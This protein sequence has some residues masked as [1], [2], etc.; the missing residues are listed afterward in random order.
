MKYLHTLDSRSAST[1]CRVVASDSEGE[2][3][4]KTDREHP[5]L[6]YMH[7]LKIIMYILKMISLIFVSFLCFYHIYPTYSFVPINKSFNIRSNQASTLQMSILEIDPNYNLAAG[8]A[9][10]GLICGVLEDQKSNND[11]IFKSILTK[12]SGASAVLFTIFGIF[13]AYQTTT[14]RFTFDDTNKS[15]SLVKAGNSNDNKSIGEN[16]VVGGESIKI[17]STPSPINYFDYFSKSGNSKIF[18]LNL[19]I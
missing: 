8:S 16:I 6:I 13:V 3:P 17:I 12:I 14:L 19:V 18:I 4:P 11:G 1:G 10:I 7:I 9:V 15:F 2:S 5:M